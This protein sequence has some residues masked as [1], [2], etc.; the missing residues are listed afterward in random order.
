MQKSIS[1]ALK[2]LRLLENRTEEEEMRPPEFA[3]DTGR[4]FMGDTEYLRSYI[5]N[6]HENKA[7]SNLG[8]AMLLM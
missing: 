3:I 6:R 5:V 8:S 1:A 7:G 2:F 4:K